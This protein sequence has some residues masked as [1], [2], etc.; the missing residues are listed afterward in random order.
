MSKE[1]LFFYCFGAVMCA[2]SNAIA[3]SHIALF[4]KVVTFFC[5]MTL[6]GILCRVLHHAI[7]GGKF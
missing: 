2:V 6:L 1:N 3:S 5:T 7:F 4:V